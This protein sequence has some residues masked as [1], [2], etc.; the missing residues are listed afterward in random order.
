M[1]SKTKCLCLHKTICHNIH[2]KEILKKKKKSFYCVQLIGTNPITITLNYLWRHFHRVL[3]ERKLIV[4]N[5]EV[6]FQR[7]FQGLFFSLILYKSIWCQLNHYTTGFFFSRIIC[8]WRDPTFYSFANNLKII[9]K[10]NNCVFGFSFKS[11]YLNCI[12][13]RSWNR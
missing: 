6:A 12:F 9:I 2:Y 7:N 1:F 10:R 5:Y 4:L 13:S 11:W 8:S 3:Y